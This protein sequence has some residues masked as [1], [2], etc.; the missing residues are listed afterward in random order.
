[1]ISRYLFPT[2]D[3]CEVVTRYCVSCASHSLCLVMT[4]NID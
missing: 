3:S 1:L 4:L 2:K